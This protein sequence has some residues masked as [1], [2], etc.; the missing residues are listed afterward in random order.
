MFEIK[1]ARADA[2][3][4]Q[5]REKVEPECV[6]QIEEVLD[7]KAAEGSK[8]RVMPDLHGGAGICIGFTQKIADRVVPNFVGVDIGCGMLVAR[9]DGKRTRAIFGNE[10][11]LKRLDR[12]WR[13]EIPMG[14][15]H[16]RGPHA[17]AANVHLENVRAPVNREKL[18][19]S[20]GTL[21]G[22]NHFGEL[23]RDEETGDHWLV[24]HSGSR[25]LGVEVARHYQKLACELRDARGDSDVPDH[26]AW[27]EGEALDDYLNDMKWA[28][29][30]AA[31]NREAMLDEIVRAFNLK[32]FLVEKFCTVHNYIDLGNG[33]VRKGAISLA[34]GER[35]IV[36]LNMRDGSLIV[37]GKGNPDWNFSGPHG[38][39]RVLSRTAARETLRMQ[40]FRS[41]MAGI[42]TTSVSAATI[43]ESPMAYKPAEEIV[44]QIGETCDVETRIR[45]VWNVK[46]GDGE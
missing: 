25:H 6:R 5:D 8:I 19:L 13:N 43:D 42:Y 17:F 27:L 41:A 3:V 15:N 11:G 18:L 16:R 22:G 35:A 14:W 40:D 9:F 24:I 28:Q 29:E 12:V 23:D 46:A 38:A 34:A 33:I 37:R 21:G 45:P 31:W 26:L 1:G 2:V 4:F 7:S 10:M 20:V 44:G 39:G 36:P 32:K 30:F